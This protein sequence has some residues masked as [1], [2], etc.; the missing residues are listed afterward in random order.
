MTSFGV[1]VDLQAAAAVAHAER[2]PGQGA[3]Q[4][5][6]EGQRAAVVAH[7]AEAGDRGDPRAG[8]R[9]DVQAVAGV[10]HQVAE[11]HPGGLAEVVVGE[12]DVPDLRRDDRLGARAQRAVAHRDRLVV[13]EVARLLLVAE[14]VAAQVEREHEVGLL[15]HLRAVELVVRDVQQQRELQ[16]LEVQQRVVG[17]ALRLRVDLQPLVVRDVHRVGRVAPRGDLLVVDAELMRALAEMRRRAPRRCA[18]SAR[19]SGSCR[20]CRRRARSTRPGR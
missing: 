13:G 19:P 6:L 17:E 7:P 12:L 3:G 11:V 2:Q 20:R 10:L 9:C 18:G 8:E 4:A 15:D 1:H 16:A 14:A 5:R